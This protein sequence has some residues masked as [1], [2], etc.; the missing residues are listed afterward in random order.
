MNYEELWAK[1]EAQVR[2]AL[3]LG[4]ETAIREAVCKR[5]LE[6]SC[7]TNQMFDALAGMAQ[8]EVAEVRA[9]KEQALQ[10]V[11]SLVKRKVGQVKARVTRPPM[12]LHVPMLRNSKAAASAA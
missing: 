4:D 3:P 12:G 5:I 6:K 1:Y 8:A 10:F 11:T 9:E 7:C 2:A